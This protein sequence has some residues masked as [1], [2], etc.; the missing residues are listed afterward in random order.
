METLYR[1]FTPDLE[2]R[3]RGD[4]RT[5]YGIVVPYEAPTRISDDL[6]EQFARGAFNHQ[7]KDPARVKFAR[8]HMALGGDL[9]GAGSLMRDDAAGLYMELRVSRTPRGEE[10][11]ELVKDGALSHL[12]VA[13]HPRQNR[14][15][16]A[17]RLERVS[18][19]LFEVASVV[20]GA[21]GDLAA[22]AGVRVHQPQLAAEELDLREQAA[23]FLDLPDL[24][25]YDTQIRKIRLGLPRT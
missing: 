18:A 12:S 19:D 4:G 22:A 21:Y 1:S 9:I 15:L 23:A 10:T 2:V 5:I 11:L 16:G 24:P 25:D 14:R 13:F 20:Q 7:L 17:G 8:D 3:S 6:I